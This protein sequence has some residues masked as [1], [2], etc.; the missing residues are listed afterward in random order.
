M[1]IFQWSFNDS[2][3]LKEADRT[4]MKGDGHPFIGILQEDL[5]ELNMDGI[6]L[7]LM[8]K[9]HLQNLIGQVSG[10]VLM[11]NEKSHPC[12]GVMGFVHSG[13]GP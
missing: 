5:L 8:I 12:Q 11:N 6:Q 4:R 7:C 13:I 3:F 2:L 9:D 1:A 10:K